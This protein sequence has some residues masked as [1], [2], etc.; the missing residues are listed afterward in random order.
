MS[1]TLNGSWGQLSI[2]VTFEE[3]IGSL[4]IYDEDVTSENVGEYTFDT[5]E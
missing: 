3:D 5:E 2:N 4:L 1:R